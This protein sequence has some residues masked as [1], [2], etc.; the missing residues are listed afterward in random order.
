M[1][2][3]RNQVWQHKVILIKNQKHLDPKK[4]WKLVRMLDPNASDGHSHGQLGDFRKKGGM[5]VV[6]ILIDTPQLQHN[7]VIYLL[8]LMIYV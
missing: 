3:L 8:I 1:N 5:L 7:S 6:R 4:Q 2:H